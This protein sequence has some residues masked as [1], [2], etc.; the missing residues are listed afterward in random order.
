MKAS[1]EP[2]PPN[3]QTLQ[4]STK[5]IVQDLIGR[6]PEDVIGRELPSWVARQPFHH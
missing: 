6:L 3:A 1:L 5:Q 4:M 2:L